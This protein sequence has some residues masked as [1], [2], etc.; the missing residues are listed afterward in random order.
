[1]DKKNKKVNEQIFNKLNQLKKEVSN[2]LKQPKKEK[3]II[4]EVAKQVIEKSKKT[5]ADIAILESDINIPKKDKLYRQDDEAQSLMASTS[6]NPTLTRTDD[7]KIN[8]INEI[9]NSTKEEKFNDPRY[10]ID[11]ER[12]VMWKSFLK[13]KYGDENYTKSTLADTIE[14]DEI[15]RKWDYQND[16]KRNKNHKNHSDSPFKDT[17]KTNWELGDVEEKIKES[18]WK[19]NELPSQIEQL[20]ELRKQATQS[21][22]GMIYVPNSIINA[23]K[24]TGKRDHTS[25]ITGMETFYNEEDYN[26]K[27]SAFSI[28]KLIIEKEQEIERA[29]KDL[30]K[31]KVLYNEYNQRIEDLNKQLNLLQKPIA[32][33]GG[34]LTQVLTD[35][36]KA[37]NMGVAIGTSVGVGAVAGAFGASASTAGA[38]DLLG[39]ITVGGIQDVSDKIHMVQTMKVEI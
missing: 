1:M 8:Q 18:G 39:D 34:G 17:F 29:N 25:D 16:P 20:K 21:K 24:E 11:E 3:N 4:E 35:E 13:Q 31:N 32:M 5:R 23:D 27:M 10:Q 36:Y 6:T 2:L 7:T 22:D 15:K 28:H 37:K 38:L 19:K 26:T 14:F 12:Q 9:A 33:V 30:E